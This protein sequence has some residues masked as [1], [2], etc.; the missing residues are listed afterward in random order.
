MSLRTTPSEALLQSIRSHNCVLFLG[1]G[2]GYYLRNQNGETCPDG[3]SLTKKLCNEF[4]LDNNT[5]EDLSI[6]S[7]L[8]EIRKNRGT[9]LDFLRKQLLDFYPDE[10]YLW[11]STIS[12][13]AIYTTNFDD[14]L[15]INGLFPGSFA[16]T[17]G[18]TYEFKV[19]IDDISPQGSSF[20]IWI[21]WDGKG[22]NPPVREYY[23]HNLVNNEV[24]VPI[25]V[26]QFASKRSS[27][28][29]F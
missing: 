24:V 23:N 5:V 2:M 22:N 1:A 28:A 21:D 8:V 16:L 6:A 10:N 18:Q 15:L 4:N 3:E 14:G 25:E 17:K 29:V 27:L 12:W 20:Y 26:P 9:L 19:M 11:L 13:R 7:E